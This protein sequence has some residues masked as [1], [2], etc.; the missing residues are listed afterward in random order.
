[1]RYVAW[2]IFGLLFS[3][4]FFAL[5]LLIST[6]F[7]MTLIGVVWFVRSQWLLPWFPLLLYMAVAAFLTDHLRQCPRDERQ[8]TYIDDLQS[9]CL[10]LFTFSFLALTFL[11]TRV[12]Q[13]DG[14]NTELLFPALGTALVSFIGGY[15]GYQFRTKEAWIYFSNA[16][17]DNG[18]WCII[19]SLVLLGRDVIQNESLGAVS[20]LAMVAFWVYLIWNAFNFLSLKYGRSALVS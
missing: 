10:S 8:G 14:A 15:I 6:V 13:V 11:V 1:M 17:H 20:V 19:F 12:G 3:I 18:L 2:A 5:L 16:A 7:G 4:S 9:K